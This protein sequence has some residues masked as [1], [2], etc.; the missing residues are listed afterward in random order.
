MNMKSK[1]LIL[2]R[3][4]KSS[5]DSGAASDFERP[6]NRRGMKDSRRLGRFIAERNWEPHWVITSPALRASTTCDLVCEPLEVPSTRIWRDRRVYDAS[7]QTLKNVI[8]ET[9]DLPGR[10]F[11]VG[12][13]PGL[14]S[15]LLEL[16]PS[17]PVM[18]NGKLFTTA[19]LARI[20]LSGRWD[21]LS[22]GS[23]KLLELVRPS[24]LD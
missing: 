10:L 8:G 13:N 12:H 1:E 11:M 22:E 7:L 20:E 23:G 9:P 3:H 24:D 14:E 18:D 19:N 2:I 6:L 21:D 15:L 17:A 5:W 16:C 4:G